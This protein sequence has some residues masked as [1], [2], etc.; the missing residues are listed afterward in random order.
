MDKQKHALHASKFPHEGV[1]EE[2]LLSQAAI[3][4]ADA[5]VESNLF[6]QPPNN[7][8]ESIA[9]CVYM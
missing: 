7:C 8:D 9:L 1:I 2:I 4:E 6:P 5:S 3:M